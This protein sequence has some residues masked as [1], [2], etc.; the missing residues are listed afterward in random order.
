M[1]VWSNIAYVIAGLLLWE[2]PFI[3]MSMIALG[4][5]SALAHAKGGWY[6]KL[7]WSAMFGTF[8]AIALHPFG[9][10][11]LAVIFALIGYKYGVDNYIAFS[12]V[13]ALSVLSAHLSGVPVLFPITIFAV[14]LVSQLYA[15]SEYGT[16]TYEIYHSIW[17]VL[18]AIAIYLLV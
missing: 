8:G 11:Y 9:L 1:S 14:A 12:F 13:W 7:D 4:I 15:E 16:T 5:T 6:W 18:T 10:S 17:H 2:T 3:S